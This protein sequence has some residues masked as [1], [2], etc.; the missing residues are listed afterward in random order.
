MEAKLAALRLE[1]DREWQA[2]QRARAAAVRATSSRRAR[3]RSLPLFLAAVAMLG[4]LPFY[5][6][7]RGAVYL[8]ESEGWPAY[9]ALG[10]GVF[11]TL[12]IV[13]AYAT[14]LLRRVAGRRARVR[15]GLVLRWLALPMVS[16]YAGYALV[17][18]AGA[19]V[20][21]PAVRATYTSLH[22]LLRVALA[23][24]ILADDNLMITD[25]SRAPAD[26]G[27]MGLPLN[28]SSL[29]YRQRDG[30]VHAVDLRTA[31]RGAIRNA[32]TQAYFWVM[33]FDTLRHVGTADHLHVS[34]S[35]P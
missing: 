29:H 35:P 34:L 14:W 25:M 9:G 2:R 33:G 30:Y 10:G 18:V 23:T 31:G 28:D 7:V 17:Y 1:A 21:S 15:A 26:Y 19:H 11:L 22:P 12:L 32:L 13:T 6:L 27:R 20:K 3:V 16:F 4:A 5:A 8:H 24:L